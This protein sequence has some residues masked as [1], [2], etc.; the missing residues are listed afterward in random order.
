MKFKSFVAAAAMGAAVLA[1]PQFA[2]AAGDAV[3]GKKVF[4]K[5]TACHTVEAGKHKIGP[6]LA[7]IFGKKSGQVDGYGRYSKGVAK[8]EVVWDEANLDKWLENPKKF[9]KGAKMTFKLRKPDQRADVIA[10]LKS[11]N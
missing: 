9:I 8:G 4:K 11:L 3:K 10:Y 1:A 5:C 6:S 2:H 7:G